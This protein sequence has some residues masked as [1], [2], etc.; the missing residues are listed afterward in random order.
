MARDLATRGADFILHYAARSPERM[1]F[2]AELRAIAGPRLKTWL[3]SA[4]GGSTFRRRS[5]RGMPDGTFM[6]AARVA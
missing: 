2:R 6:S 4:A 5:A 3:G 1:A